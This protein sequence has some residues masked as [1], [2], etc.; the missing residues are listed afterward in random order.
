MLH[1]APAHTSIDLVV[2]LPNQ[3]IVFTGDIIVAIR[4]DLIIHLE[5]NGSTEGLIKN[6]E[7][8]SRAGRHHFCSRPRKSENEEEV[9]KRLAGIVRKRDEIKKLISEGKTCPK[10]RRR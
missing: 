3:K 4:P 6:Y 9:Q 10:S 1:W 7:G 5:K 8:H 2:Y